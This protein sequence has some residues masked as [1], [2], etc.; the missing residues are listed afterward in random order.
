MTATRLALCPLEDRTVPATAGFGTGVTGPIPVT[1]GLIGPGL[2]GFNN[3]PANLLV[4]GVP[5]GTGTL[6]VPNVNLNGYTTPGATRQLLPGFG[7]AVR[8]AL[9]DVNGDGTADLIAGAGPG[10]QRVVVYDGVTNGLLADFLPF[11]A[12]FAGGVYVSAGDV[13]QDGRAEV[14][15]T[16]DRTG[17]PRVSVFNGTDLAAG[18]T[19]RIADFLG[20]A[21]RSGVLDTAFRGGA[22]TAV[23]DVNG[24][25]FLDVIVAA[26]FGGG[27]RVTIWDGGNLPPLGVAPTALTTT[28]GVAASPG[29]STGVV[30]TTGAPTSPGG[31]TTTFAGAA[32]IPGA[33]TSTLP[34]AGAAGIPQVGATILP[35]VSVG[36][37]GSVGTAT[38]PTAG[39]ANLP[40][41]G[42][43]TLPTAGTAGIPQAGTT[44]LPAAGTGTATTTAFISPALPIANFF[45]FEE[46]L[47]NGVFVA[48]GD[49]NGDGC[50]D[51]IFG[52]GPGGGPRVRV[53]D[54]NS[55]ALETADFS[56]DDTNRGGFTLADFFAGDPDTRGGVR[57]AAREI[58]GDGLADVA[59]GSGVGLPSAVRLYLG[60]SLAAGPT[61]PAVSQTF[62]PFG[63]VLADGV[64]VG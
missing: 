47:R 8:T 23:A 37:P 62:D 41:A 40:A 24:N 59:T 63:A 29:V 13:N 4:G 44:V 5:D 17:G 52:G 61:N 50:A 28:T 18:N 56:L 20:L 51:L 31:T 58:D 49:V 25:G 33:G 7:G 21:D 14:V 34:A 19:V 45:A 57:V 35:V 27:P 39:T 30:G 54:G 48:G 42:T 9:G 1:A 15:V 60:S 64:F 2:P 3:P 55:V 22:R 38:F 26:G 46:T 16:P 10:G 36:V 12:S 11:E 32:S 6:F 43:S 53:V